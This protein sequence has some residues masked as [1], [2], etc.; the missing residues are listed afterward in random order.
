VVVIAVLDDA[1]VVLRPEGRGEIDA[2]SALVLVVAFGLLYGALMGTFY[3]EGQWPRGLQAFYSAVKVPLL[4]VMTFLLALPSFYVINLLFGLGPDFREAVR[5]LLATQAGL[6]V[7]L[8]SLGPFTLLFYSSTTNYNAAILFNGVMFGGA[9]FAAQRLLRRF[10][11][12][13]IARNER[14]RQMARLWLILYAFVGIQ[15]GWV[16]R[17]FIGRP[18]GVTEFFRPGAWGNAY[19]EVWVK[20][21]EV[22]GGKSG[23]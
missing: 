5:A 16:L 4:L 23:Y 21:V 7:I 10:Y 20:V 14:H 13:L 11:A 18:D 22:C 19:V 1:R 12:P 17:P 6:T 2:R 8:A 15:M 3:G 9:S